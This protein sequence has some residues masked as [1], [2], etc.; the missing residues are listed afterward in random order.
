MDAEAG[1]WPGE[2][3]EVMLHIRTWFQGQGYRDPADLI[4]AFATVRELIRRK[5]GPVALA[6]EAAA[7]EKLAREVSGEEVVVYWEPE[8]SQEY[9]H[10]LNIR[11]HTNYTPHKS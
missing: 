2:T 6:P 4:L 7:L 9:V 5:G 10:C 1:K 3:R 8:S 11:N